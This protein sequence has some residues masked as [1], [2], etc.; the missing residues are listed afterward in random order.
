MTSRCLAPFLS[1]EPVLL[2]LFHDA[3]AMP[4]GSLETSRGRG[5]PI[6]S[7]II[8]VTPLCHGLI[9]FPIIVVSCF[10]YIFLISLL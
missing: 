7:R 9:L 3:I 2:M 4:S 5:S 6:E 8:I 1:Q 10:T